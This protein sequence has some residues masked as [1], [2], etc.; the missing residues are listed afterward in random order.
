VRH[1]SD[2]LAMVLKTSSLNL[3]FK[4]YLNGPRLAS[5]NELLHHLTLVYLTQKHDEFEWNLHESSKFFLDSM[6]KALSSQMY[7]G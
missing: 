6:Y 2:A 5:W 7:H 4:T 1:K 3:T